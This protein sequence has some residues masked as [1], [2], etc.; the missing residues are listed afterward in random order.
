M[1]I[2]L[3]TG[4]AVSTRGCSKFTHTCS[5]VSPVSSCL[6]QTKF[7]E[8]EKTSKSESDKQ[9]KKSKAVRQE[10]R[11]V[12]DTCKILLLGYDEATLWSVLLTSQ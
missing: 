2:A 1:V 8:L 11:E 6:L 3:A 5:S 9:D 10:V 7:S 4:S 12:V